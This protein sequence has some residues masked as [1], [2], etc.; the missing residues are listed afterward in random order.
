MSSEKTAVCCSDAVVLVAKSS[1]LLIIQSVL[2]FGHAR[3]HHL[4]VFSFG[5]TNKFQEICHMIRATQSECTEREVVA[6]RADVSKVCT[7]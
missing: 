4:L 7:R 6:K 3:F 2:A 1:V 5:N